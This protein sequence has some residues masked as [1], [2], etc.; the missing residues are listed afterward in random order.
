MAIQPQPLEPIWRSDVAVAALYL[1][2]SGLL[3]ALGFRAGDAAMGTLNESKRAQVQAV[4]AVALSILGLLLG[5]SFALASSR[6]DARKALV[7]DEANAIGTAY[8]RVDL[9]PEADRDEMRGI[10]RSYIDRRLE[11][12]EQREFGRLQVEEAEAEVVRL[13]DAM[14]AVGVRAA[15]ADPHA[16]TTMLLGVA[17]IAMGTLGYGFGSSDYRNAALPALVGVLVLMIV[18]VIVDLDRPQAGFIRVSQ[19][20]LE[21]TR[22]EML[23][24]A[25]TVR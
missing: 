5:F 2:L 22:G 4:Q 24:P 7:A 23:R 16:V 1:S 17:A 11:F 21:S 3:F 15:R 13:H 10:L 6:F 18:V 19:R 25:S 9:L 8:R 20:A 12:V 14:W